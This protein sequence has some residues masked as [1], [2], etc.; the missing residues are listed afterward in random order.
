MKAMDGVGFLSTLLAIGA[1]WFGRWLGYRRGYADGEQAEYTRW[2]LLEAERQMQKPRLQAMSVSVEEIHDA[3][4]KK[5][6]R[7]PLGLD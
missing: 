5:A 6:R 3:L 7:G 2:R 1:F 4:L